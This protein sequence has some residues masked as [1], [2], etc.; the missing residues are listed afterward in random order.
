MTFLGSNL[1]NINIRKVSKMSIASV[2]I[3]FL[4]FIS[5]K[6]II[7]KSRIDT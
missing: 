4:I 6:K 3:L 2:K 1:D 7:K 5:G